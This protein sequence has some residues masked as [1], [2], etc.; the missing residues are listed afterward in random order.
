MTR[1]LTLVAA[2]V[3]GAAAGC[4][5]GESAPAD[6]RAE[7]PASLLYAELEQG[8]GWDIVR[9]DVASGRRTNLT[10]TPSTPA[11]DRDERSPVLSADGSL[12]AYTS[13]ADHVS[14]G[15]VA[16]EIFV[17]GSDGRRPLRLTNDDDV[18][19]APQ[20]TPAGRIAFLHCPSAQEAV[21]SC[22]IDSIAPNGSDRR[23][24]VESVGLAYDVAVSPD[25]ARL[26]YV[27]FDERLR[28]RGLFVRDLE[29]GVE[30]RVAD[31]GSGPRWS[32]DGRRLAF[33][34]G[35]DR[36]GPCLFPECSGH[37]PEVYVARADGSDETRLT[38]T[39]ASEGYVG[40]TPDGEWILF[41]RMGDERGG[42]DLF[43]VRADGGCE[44]QL[45]DTP[46][47]EWSAS[48]RGRTD[49]LACD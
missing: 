23:T 28:P 27:G 25:G 39:T 46:A 35:R 40:W 1:V 38:E 18:D 42:Y 37:A 8:R 20:W 7:G 30:Q 17:M 22:R 4:G 13:T 3:L 31:E 19:V 10:R 24:A 5:G 29:S 14:D 43:A 33:V 45:T 41:S 11:G 26:A 49:S 16:E 9:E 6:A 47:W 34:S 44:T 15:D 2:L 12:I 32:P 48:W 36:N 21:S